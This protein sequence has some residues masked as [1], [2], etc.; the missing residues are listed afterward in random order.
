MASQSTWRTASSAKRRQCCSWSWEW[1]LE[2]P[3][4]GSKTPV[5]W[6]RPG[7]LRT[8]DRHNRAQTRDL[9]LKPSTRTILQVSRLQDHANTPIGQMSS[10]RQW[11]GRS[12]FNPSR[13]IPKTPK[14][15]LDASVLSTQNYKVRIKGKLSNPGKG[16][17]NEKGAIGYPR[18]S[19]PTLPLVKC[20]II[21][22]L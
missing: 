10:V 4:S 11:F 21:V 15:V 6:M 1:L 2:E 5:C 3:T 8:P 16:V 13:V 18:L 7:L 20:Y 19:S 22:T 12:E 17:A 9:T 14:M